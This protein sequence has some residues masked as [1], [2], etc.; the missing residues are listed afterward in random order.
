VLFTREPIIETVITARNGYRLSVRNSKSPVEEL[1]VDA[2]EIVSFGQALFFRC[3]ERP[4]AFL[5]PVSDYE[6]SEVRET[7]LVLKHMVQEGKKNNESRAH[8]KHEPKVEARVEEPKPSEEVESNEAKDS[9]NHSR[10]DRRRERRRQRRRRGDGRNEPGTS[11][12]EAE[13]AD[14][15]AEPGEIQGATL[16][17]GETATVSQETASE[18][19]PSKRNSRQKGVMQLVSAL[20]PPPPT[21]VS[22]LFRYEH[23]DNEGVRQA[24]GQS[25]DHVQQARH[26]LV[27]AL[28]ARDEIDLI[29]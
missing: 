28:H 23:L 11:G 10:N 22:D 24:V 25:E 19:T 5:F 27:D 2:L 7:R 14:E 9:A 26:Q 4:K 13:S 20:I 8:S 29:P 21:L 15:E 6:V 18:G 1:L 17:G 16:E 3:V 12:V